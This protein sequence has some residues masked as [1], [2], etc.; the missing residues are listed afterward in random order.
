MKPLSAWTFCRRHKGR[1]LMLTALLAPA[2]IGLYLLVSL[3]Q[4]SCVAPEYTINRHL[5]KFSSV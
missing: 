4:E 3:F 5:S 1:A 2:V